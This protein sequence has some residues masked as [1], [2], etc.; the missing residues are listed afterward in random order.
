MTKAYLLRL[1][2]WISLAFALPLAVVIVTG[3]I[4]SFEPIAQQRSIEPG[5]LTLAAVEAVLARADPEGKAGGLSIAP[6]DGVVNVG[7]GP[8]TAP[9]VFDMATGEPREAGLWSGVFGAS[10]FVHERLIGNLGWLVIASTVAMLVI[11]ALGVLMGLPRLANSVSGWHKGTAWFLLP[12]VIL[13]P[14][15]G[16][17][18]VLGITLSGPAPTAGPAPARLVEAVRM[19]AADH[20]LSALNSIR[21]RGQTMVARVWEDGRL[22]AFAATDKGLVR[23]GSNWPRLLHEGNGFGIWGA[24]ANVV[25]SVAFVGLLG[26]GLVIWTR[27]TFRRRNRVRAPR[28][29]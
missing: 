26:T 4:L 25:V 23:M 11:V 24:L 17:A 13:S 20:D 2:R 21:R 19:V 15:T 14:L 22:V 8:G 18:L 16:L 3:L 1:H 28:P 5:S 7:G 9:K 27:R 6:H 10:R 12:L 29:A